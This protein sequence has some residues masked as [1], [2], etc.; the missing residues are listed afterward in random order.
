MARRLLAPLAKAITSN[1]LF[2]GLNPEQKQAAGHK[3]GPMAVL[4]QA[5]TGKTKT[6][7]SLVGNLIANGCP[8]ERILAVT[9]SKKAADE[10]GQR[11]SAA[12]YS[13][14][15]STWHAFA[16][17]VLFTDKTIWSRWTIDESDRA[18]YAVKEA[19]GYK[20]LDWKT[21]DLGDVRKFIGFCKAHNLIPS[22]KGCEVQA[23]RFFKPEDVSKAIRAYAI[24]QDLIETQGLLT[25]D[26]MLMFAAR[27][28]SQEYNRANWA[29][30]FDWVLQDEAQDSNPVQTEI[31]ELLTRESGNY[32]VI[33]DPAQSIYGFRGS[34]P[35]AVTD[36]SR[37]YPNARVVTMNR[38][39]R[40]AKA[41]VDVANDIIRKAKIR[42]PVDM[43]A[44][45]EMQGSVSPVR[46]ANFDDEGEQFASYVECTV[47]EGRKYAD[48]TCLFRTN[49]QSRALEESLIARRIPYLIVGG[50]SFYE[51]K[52]IKDLLSYARIATGVQ[53]DEDAC[54]R[55]IN[56]P[57]RFLGA[58]FVEKVWACKRPELSWEDAASV[59]SRQAGVQARQ[60]TSVQAWI[61]AIATVQDGIKANETPDQILTSL[62]KKVD[63]L[64]WLSRDE[65]GESIESSHAANIRELIRVAAKFKTIEELLAYIEKSIQAA[66]RQRKEGSAGGDRVLLM[67]VHRSKGLEWPCVWV[68]GCNEKILP[69]AHGDIEEERRLMYVAAT[70][71]REEL[72][73]SYVK[74]FATAEGIKE[75]HPSRFLLD[76]NLI[77]PA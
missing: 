29:G 26:D 16:R 53:A 46:A 9:F 66:A 33:G 23:R 2:S 28:L 70:R 5:G 68:V 59:A 58:K 7:V 35:A 63:F 72:T 76:A 24:S 49:A 31:A 67:S 75:A 43:S 21:A 15:F 37:R 41:I 62:V 74:S 25:F 39:Y 19:L 54:K 32:V 20:Y 48:I 50:T 60:R 73:L 40:C 51:R 22:D 45:V 44:E 56:A 8:G 64:G 13:G 65:G 69:H 61:E 1:P 11:A 47:K 52:E 55:S 71:A 18:K 34:S 4:S 38:N 3:S 57:F 12:G 36:F 77:N 10:M 27:H 17:D 14:R 6:L 30:K 42:L